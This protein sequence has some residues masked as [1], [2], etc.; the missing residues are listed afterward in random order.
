MIS[1]STN[2]RRAIRDR[3]RGFIINPFAFAAQ[4]TDRVL[5]D[6]EGSNGSQTF[7]DTG[8]AGTTWSAS[9]AGTALT[10]GTILAGTSSLGVTAGTDY[11]EAAAASG[12]MLP[13]TGNWS[14]RFRIRAGT[15]TSGGLGRY[16]VSCQ[17]TAGN[18][19]DTHIVLATN[20]S[21]VVS[22]ILS[23]GTTRSTVISSGFSMAVNTTYNIEVNRVGS[24][25]NLI[26]DGTSRASATF[27]GSINRP[28]GRKWRIGA[29][30]F[31][32]NGASNIVFD[33]FR[34]SY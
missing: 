31:A 15:L 6:F 8:S 33:S 27:T 19:A 3:Q 13:A 4:L 18:A 9:G 5:M 2:I 22:V 34:I 32:A 20:A 24:T 7:T 10:T 11:M 16:L 14:I 28:S 1:R 17:G 30:E 25:I 23:D 26:V 21:S 29:P 12:N